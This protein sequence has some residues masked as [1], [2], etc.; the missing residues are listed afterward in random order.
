MSILIVGA[1]GSMGQRYQAILSRLDI[2]C[3]PLDLIHTDADY[4]YQAAKSDGI[5][6]ATPTHTHCDLINK[7][8][9]YKIPILCEK[10]MSKNMAELNET[11]DYVKSEKANLTMTLQYD[12]LDD[13]QG[14]GLS[15]YDYFRHGSDGLIWDCI[16]VIGLAR[17]NVYLSEESPIWRCHLNGRQLQFS[18]MD[19][20]YVKFIKDWLREPGEDT[21]RIIDIHAKTHEY[22]REN[23]K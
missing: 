14:A 8:V 10:P 19:V 23:W 3:A 7:F 6:I 4:Q 13:K 12:V 20:A 16:Q 5:I 9:P 1:N 15:Y 18:D 2:S 21:S 17:G 22:V 11:L